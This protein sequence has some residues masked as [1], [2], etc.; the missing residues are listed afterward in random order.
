MRRWMRE[1]NAMSRIPDFTTV[2]FADAACGRPDDADGAGAET[3][4]GRDLLMKRRP[5]GDAPGPVLP[6]RIR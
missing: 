4:K 6:R 1:E 2:D 3:R 5:G